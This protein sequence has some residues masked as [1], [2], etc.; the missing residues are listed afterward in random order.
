[1]NHFF[2]KLK[3]DETG[4][5]LMEVIIAFAIFSVF[6]LMFIGAVSMFGNMRLQT[7]E[8]QNASETSSSVLEYEDMLDSNNTNLLKG[9]AI[10]V[11]PTLNG[12]SSS[13]TD[14]IAGNYISAQSLKRD[15]VIQQIFMS[16]KG[17]QPDVDPDEEEKPDGPVPADRVDRHCWQPDEVGGVSQNYKIGEVVCYGGSGHGASG[18]VYYTPIQNFSGTVT[19]FSSPDLVPAMWGRTNPPIYNGNLDD[20]LLIWDK[21]TYYA[22][23]TWVRYPVDGN[24]YK[25]KTVLTQSIYYYS[26]TDTRYWELIK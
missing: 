5:T 10:I 18:H 4:M 11:F 26:P 21:D 22:P 8:Y 19:N 13:V 17:P 14:G 3:T 25:V 12:K 23:G 24:I 1:M 20:Y 7:K 15:T 16:E 9:E 2:K 6:I